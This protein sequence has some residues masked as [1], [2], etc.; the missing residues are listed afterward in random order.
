MNL[1][2]KKENTYGHPYHDYSTIS[3]TFNFF[4]VLYYYSTQLIEEINDWVTFHRISK[5]KSYPKRIYFETPQIM[6]SNF[7]YFLNHSH[8]CD[9]EIIFV[10]QSRAS[11]FQHQHARAGWD[12]TRF[13]FPYG[14]TPAATLKKDQEEYM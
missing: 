8:I 9:Q 12:S 14:F 3:G 1:Q 5:P 10:Y 7:Y 11:L 2:S 13:L 4:P 6:S